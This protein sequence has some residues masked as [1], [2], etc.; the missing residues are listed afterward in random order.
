MSIKN[1]N[2]TLLNYQN[3]RKHTREKIKKERG[4]ERMSILKGL[5]NF[6]SN[7]TPVGRMVT[8]G[9]NIDEAVKGAYRET[10]ENIF[11]NQRTKFS[12]FYA[13]TKSKLES[14]DLGLIEKIKIKLG[15]SD[16]KTEQEKIQ[17][18]LDKAEE[19]YNKNINEINS[20]EAQLLEQLD[21]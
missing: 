6:V 4:G 11:D 9:E 15:L 7:N 13:E 2:V 19:N 17:K 10:T 3:T 8:K 1:F 21:K 16:E 20:K 18:T 12:D 5:G 14:K